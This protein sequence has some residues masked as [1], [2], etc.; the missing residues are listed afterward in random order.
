MDWLYSYIVNNLLLISIFIVVLVIQ[1]LWNIKTTRQLLLI[2]EREAATE[3]AVSD[4]QMAMNML[5]ERINEA[6]AEN[7]SNALEDSQV[8]KQLEH[9]IKTLQGQLHQLGDSLELI[10]EQQPQDKLYSRAYKLAALGADI[11]EIM[12]ECELPRAEAEM[13]LSVYHQKQNK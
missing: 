6:I 7:E 12:A 8:S 2:A 9:R 10:K 1:W 3:L 11:E 5:E 13:L 4:I